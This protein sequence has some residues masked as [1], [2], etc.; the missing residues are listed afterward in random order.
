M[1]PAYIW[2]A[3]YEASEVRNHRQVLIHR[4]FESYRSQ[5]QSQVAGDS[6]LDVCVFQGETA[7]TQGHNAH[8]NDVGVLFIV[9]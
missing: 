8:L 2:R 3:S 1:L 4:Q 6:E 9:L 7:E 5:K